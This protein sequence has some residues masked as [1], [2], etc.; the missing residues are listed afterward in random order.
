[1]RGLP[2]RHET[3]TLLRYNV[4]LTHRRRVAPPP[5]RATDC[6]E[7]M[8]DETKSTERA[9]ISVLGADRSG[10]VAAVASLLAERDVNI[11]DISQTILQGMFTMTMLVDLAGAD[12]SQIHDGFD[13]LSKQLGVQIAIQR[14]DVFKFM[15]RL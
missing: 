13:A 3:E 5:A 14:E 2:A 11:L 6:E 1:M 9:I 4:T 12:F 15:Y 8:S 10:I 7:H